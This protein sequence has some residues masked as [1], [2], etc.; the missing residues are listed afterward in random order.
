MSSFGGHGIT[1]SDCGNEGQLNNHLK[2][3]IQAVVAELPRF[4]NRLAG[5]EL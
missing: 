5:D 3:A 4:R 2:V 1:W